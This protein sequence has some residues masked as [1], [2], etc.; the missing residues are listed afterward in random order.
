MTEKKRLFGLDLIKAISIVGVVTLHIFGPFFMHAKGSF[1]IEGDTMFF[2][3]LYYLATPAIPLFFMTNGYLILGKDN[4]SYKYCLK[5][6]WNLLIPVFVW[7]LILW[8]GKSVH[9][10]NGLSYPKIV[11]SS[12]IQKGFFFQFWFIGALSIMLF[13]APIMNFILNNNYGLYVFV[14]VLLVIFC[15][16]LDIINHYHG[17]T[18]Q[19]NVIQTFRIWT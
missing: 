8:I 11:V 5:K 15:G 14:T 1:D 2:R 18:I 17:F 12:L 10:Y 19:K 3:V 13:L 16:S 7:N 9:T 4:L 6:I